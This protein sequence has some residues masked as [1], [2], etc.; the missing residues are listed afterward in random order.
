M[1]MPGK[2]A[3]NHART[4]PMLKPSSRS[5]ASTRWLPRRLSQTGCVDAQHPSAPVAGAIAYDVRVPFWS[6]GAK[7]Q[8]Y[9]YLPPGKRVRV[10]ADGDLEVPPGSVL[11]KN[12]FLKEQLFETRFYVRHSDGE[13]SG[14]AYAW[15]A[16]GRDATLVE[17]TRVAKVRGKDWVFPGRDACNQ[18]H[19]SAAGFTLGLELRQLDI[20]EASGSQLSRLV[21]QG[22]FESPPG[23]VGRP[24]STEAPEP[25][26]S[27]ARAYL[28]TNC[29]GCHRPKGPGRVGLDLRFDT[30]LG[31][32]GLCE[33]AELGPLSGP[34]ER[35]ALLLAPGHPRQSVL[36]QRLS[37]RGPNQM[38]PL[39][40]LAVDTRGA[41]L[42][43]EYIHS[44]ASCP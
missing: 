13:Y 17:E 39:A 21:A 20:A 3:W 25:L 35:P 19:T 7:K 28:H 36:H 6:D 22:V 14:Y 2:I 44:L 12:F 18:C 11:V 32:T 29:S 43:G 27:R 5:E 9:L 15:D 40:S 4:S 30:P 41:A 38:P 24:F 1:R 42:I 37:R 10:L 34:A 31:D 26:A 33:R 8:R 16:E 23:N